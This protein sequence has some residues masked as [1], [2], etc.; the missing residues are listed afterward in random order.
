M[1]PGT[2]A[3]LAAYAVLALYLIH[4]AWSGSRPQLA[5]GNP[6]CIQATW[7]LGWVAFAVTHLRDPLVTTYLSPPGHPIGLMWNDSAPLLGLLLAPLTLTAGPVAAYD[8]AIALGL[9]LSAS[10]AAIAIGRLTR[11]SGAAWVGGLVFGFSPWVIWEAWGGHPFL[12]NLWLLPLFFL[13]VVRVVVADDQASRWLGVTLGLVST[14]QLLISQELFADAMLLGLLTALGLAVAG[15]REVGDRWARVARRLLLAVTTFVA[16]AGAPIAIAVLGPGHGL[17]GGIGSPLKDAADLLD[18]V[19]PHRGELL[20]PLGA[21]VLTSQWGGY[22]GQ[23]VYL[24]LPLL[25]VVG[26][27]CWRHPKDPWVRGSACL[28]AVAALLALGPELRVHGTAV[29]VPLPWA[30]LA[31]LP[32]YGFGSPARIAPFVFLGAATCLALVVDRC[33]PDRPDARLAWPGL[34]AIAAVLPLLPIGPLPVWVVPT[35][36]YFTDGEVRTLPSGSVVAVAALPDPVVGLDAMLWQADAGYRFRLPWGYAYQAG[37]SRHAS[38]WGSVGALQALWLDATTGR[39]IAL[40]S[41]EGL[42]IRR[43]L[44]RWRATAIVVGPMPHRKLVVALTADVVGREPRWRGGAAVWQPVAPT[45][46]R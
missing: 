27:A 9:A 33:W 38:T 6:D 21:A 46:G 18:F 30:W 10:T 34:V 2:I 28:V 43:E 29:G 45:H 8:A 23:A 15:R 11:H 37:A 3:G 42:A 40:R 41:G 17:H 7:F 19:I 4:G 35:P 24:G 22:F 16:T 20:A 36:R 12:V 26:W 1:G 14:A 44:S 32:V 13:L 39:A 25:A 31:H 5:C